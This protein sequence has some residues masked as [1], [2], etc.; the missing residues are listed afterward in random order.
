MSKKDPYDK[1]STERS[2]RMAASNVTY[3]F[4]DESKLTM[5][6]SGSATT[7]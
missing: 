7:N 1:T 5:E 6:A 4:K 3:R 2:S